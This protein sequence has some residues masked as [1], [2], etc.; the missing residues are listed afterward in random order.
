VF[1]SAEMADAV[2]DKCMSAGMPHD[3]PAAWVYRATWEDER[4]RL[5]T[6]GDLPR[7]MRDAGVSNHAII[8][9]GDCLKPKPD[10]RSYLYSDGFRRGRA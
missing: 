9:V 10:S 4:K 3:T 7:S 8:V 2:S 6:I 5:T 1:L